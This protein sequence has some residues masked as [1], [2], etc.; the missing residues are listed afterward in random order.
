VD[1]SHFSQNLG[2]SSS[3]KIEKKIFVFGKNLIGNLL[4]VLR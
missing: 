4:L 1:F 3:S 2:S